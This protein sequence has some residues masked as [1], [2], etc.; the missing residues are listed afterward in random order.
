MTDPFAAAD[1]GF[2]D[3]RRQL[4]DIL[5]RARDNQ[6]RA[7]ALADNAH[8]LT[9]DARSPRG[10]V[11]VRAGVGGRVDSITF[12][13]SA[14][15][16]SLDALGRLIVQTIANAQHAAMARLAD[17]GAELF[18]AD[19]D[20]AQGMQRDAEQGYPQAGPTLS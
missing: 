15:R 2:A 13:D 16:M 1:A 14:E 3:A 5:A 19:S 6:A 8:A 18:G 9:A 11:T 12:G 4:D 20:I 17:R 7:Q 10:E